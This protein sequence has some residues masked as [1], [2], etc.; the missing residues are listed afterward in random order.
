MSKIQKA[1]NNVFQIYA[2]KSTQVRYTL[3][4]EVI[5]VLPKSF[6]N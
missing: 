2:N 5:E 1:L 6:S 3:C 4:D